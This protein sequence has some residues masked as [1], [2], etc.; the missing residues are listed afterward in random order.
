MSK[1]A[2]EILSGKKFIKTYYVIMKC[3]M[4]HLSIKRQTLEYVLKGET[5][6]KEA[7]NEYLCIRI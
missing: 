4:D 7:L 3:I 6:A 2:V 1:S 5:R